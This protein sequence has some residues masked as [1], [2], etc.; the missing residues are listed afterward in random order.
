MA[1][2]GETVD[3]HN[4]TCFWPEKIDFEPFD[5][6]VCFGFRE[7]R[8][9]DQPEQAAL[10]LRA[11]QPRA[12][13]MSKERSEGAD[14]GPVTSTVER[15][16]EFRVAHNPLR[17]A[18]RQRW[19][20]LVG[21][22]ARSQIDERPC[23][24][25]GGDAVLERAVASVELGQPVHVEPVTRPAAPRYD[26]YFHVGSGQFRKAPEHSC[27]AMAHEGLIA[28]GEHRREFSGSRELQPMPD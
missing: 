24:R 26:A 17:P 16:Q 18:L 2:K 14:A 9:S 27:R 20:E 8:G 13:L 19:F 21:T 11:G 23:R 7:P 10:C 22:C 28:T 12:A 1:V 3:F 5:A 15:G 25:S 4:Q 6:N